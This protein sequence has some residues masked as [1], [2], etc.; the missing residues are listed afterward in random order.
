LFTPF[1]SRVEQG[2]RERTATLDTTA[3]KCRGK[4]E[5]GRGG[6][7][8]QC[9]GPRRKTTGKKKQRG[10]YTA[11]RC[12]NPGKKFGEEGGTPQMQAERARAGSDA[13]LRA[14][15]IKGG[16]RKSFTAPW[17]KSKA[18]TKKRPGKNAKTRDKKDIHGGSKSGES[19]TQGPGDPGGN[20]KNIKAQ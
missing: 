17:T 16:G 7:R 2:E 9:K 11:K 12:K 18:S 4:V 15:D 20:A 3:V 10:F 8:K 5:V 13:G 1:K 6:S 14:Q 19:P